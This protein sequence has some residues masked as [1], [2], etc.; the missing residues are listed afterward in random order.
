[1][2]R[3]KELVS[4]LDDY[5][6]TRTIPDYSGAHNGLQVEGKEEIHRVAV[7]VDACLYSIERA[8]EAQADLLIVHHGLF[9][10][11]TVPLTGPY[12][13]RIERLVRNRLAVYSSHLPLDVHP[14]VGNNAVLARRLG[15]TPIGTFLEYRGYPL[16]V[17]AESDISLAELERR[18][19]QIGRAHV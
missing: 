5:L 2:I 1:M 15:F 14:E 4:Y 6:Q 19:Q 7:A 16:G 13:Q 12:Y 17:L 9:W 8:I 11:K 18:I 3:L 10:G